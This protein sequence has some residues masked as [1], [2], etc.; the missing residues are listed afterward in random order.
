MPVFNTARFVAAA[1]RSIAGQSFTDWE[2]I[3]I[4]DGSTDG[5]TR[6]L[7]DLANSEARIKLRIRE[8]LGLIAT[9]N[10]LLRAATGEF[11]AWMD[12]DD[13]SLP[14]RLSLQV[15]ALVD[16]P[17]LTCVGTAVQC[18][19]P[20]GHL[21]NI[22][23][24]PQEHVQIGLEQVKG[25]AQRFATTMMRR[26]Q[27]EAIGGFR[28][29]LRIG[30]DFDFLLR[31][32]ESGKLGNLPDILYLYRQHVASVCAAMGPQW[33][34]YRD[35]IL[36]LAK[37]RLN[38]GED[39]LQNGALPMVA[40]VTAR[41]RLRFESQVFLNWASYSIKNRNYVLGLKYA[42]YALVR[43]P[44]SLLVW[45][46]AVKTGLRACLRIRS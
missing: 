25:G 10:E 29:P 42:C 19:D 30:E 27:A 12:S 9:R 34:A 17:N 33:I 21:L 46:R 18:I 38:G 5:S 4:D 11:V 13:V 37:D 8:N 7:Q 6:E 15:Q 14:D 20:A 2:L 26:V 1:V 28:E 24:Y 22:E 3:I 43:S 31:L 32:G 39:R 16:D 44:F 45:K 40:Q 41:E 23:R 36:S 35:Y